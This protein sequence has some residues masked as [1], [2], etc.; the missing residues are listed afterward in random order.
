LPEKAFIVGYAGRLHTMGMSKGVDHLIEAIRLVGDPEWVFY[1]VG[2]PHDWVDRYREQWVK[3][4][5]PPEN[6]IA[7]GTVPADHI[8]LHLA[9][10]DVCTMPLPWTDHFAY[11]TSSL[12]LFE[13]MVSD[14]VILATDLPCTAEVIHHNQS[15]ILAKPDD[16]A[17]LAEGLRRLSGDGELRIRLAA[18]A[19]K[20]V[21]QYEWETRARLILAAIRT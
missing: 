9:A 6:W 19:R 17:A 20:D 5:L 3:S 15:A 10:F 18:Q 13:Y 7:T 14:R 2:G 11:Y 4:G 16:P 21:A 8:P 12:K 1:L